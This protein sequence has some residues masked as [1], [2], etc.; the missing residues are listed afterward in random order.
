MDNTLILLLQYKHCKTETLITT[1]IL[2]I[3]FYTVRKCT[4]NCVS[5]KFTIHIHFNI[6]QNLTENEISILK[7]N[8]IH[9]PLLFVDRTVIV[10]F[11]W[12]ISL[13]RPDLGKNEGRERGRERGSNWVRGDFCYF[14]HWLVLHPPLW[15]GYSLLLQPDLASF[16]QPCS[17]ATFINSFGSTRPFPPSPLICS[18]PPGREKRK[19][20][21]IFPRNCQN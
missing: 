1:Y 20:S 21:G 15:C 17:V 2:F 16:T 4:V 10:E 3:F 13:G 5:V 19:L 7:L 8:G 12:I 9:S 14:G 18:Q 6:P 11:I